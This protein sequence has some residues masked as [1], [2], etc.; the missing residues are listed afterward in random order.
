MKQEQHVIDQLNA[1]KRLKARKKQLEG[2]SVGPGVRLSA[3]SEDDHLQELHRQ[4]RKLPSYMYLDEQEQRLEA[5]AHANLSK[6]PLGTKAQLSEVI[7]SRATASPEHVRLLRELEKK[8]EKVLEA[9]AGSAGFEG[10]M[11]VIDK[12]SELQD[13]EKQLQD[14]DQA[15]DALEAYEPEYARLLK[16]RFIEGKPTEFVASELGIVDRTFRRWK[17]KALAEVVRFLSG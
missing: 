13:I 5:A 11:G 7:R 16:L 6:Y 17:Q 12:I 15:L 1:Y 9:R 8:I 4:L 3:M 2:T 10:F 14:I